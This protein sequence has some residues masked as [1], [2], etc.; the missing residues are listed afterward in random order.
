MMMYFKGSH[1]TLLY[2]TNSFFIEHVKVRHCLLYYELLILYHIIGFFEVLKFLEWPI[3]SFFAILFSRMGL[4]KLSTAMGI[5]CFFEGLNFTN[6]QHPRN[7]WNLRTS[8]N[9]LYGRWVCP[10]YQSIFK[11]PANGDK[12]DIKWLKLNYNL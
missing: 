1:L 10:W 2:L 7:S 4:Q 6:D 11:V 5:V 3:F 9:Q 8:K 12:I